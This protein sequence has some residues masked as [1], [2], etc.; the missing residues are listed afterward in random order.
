M[1]TSVSAERFAGKKFSDDVVW[2]DD[3]K[4]I[5]RKKYIKSLN[6]K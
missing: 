1:Q 2:P 3:F 4:N 6:I 5:D